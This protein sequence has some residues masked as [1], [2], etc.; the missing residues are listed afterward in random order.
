[1]SNSELY[2]SLV[3][4]PP[5]GYSQLVVDGMKLPMTAK[6]FVYFCLININ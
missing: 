4:L 1:M 6:E 2:Q 3:G 5:L